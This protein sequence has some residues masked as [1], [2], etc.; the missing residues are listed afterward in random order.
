MERIGHRGAP[1]EFPEN[2]LPAFERALALGADAIE[3][4][5]HLSAD[6]VVV[7]HH[8]PDLHVEGSGTRGKRAI[9]ALPWS[10]LS[11]IELAPGVSIPSLEQVL[12]LVGSRAR[13]YVELKGEGVEARAIEVIG[14]SGARCAVHS[15]DHAVVARAAR[16]APTLRRGILFDEYPRDVVASMRAT[17]ALDVWPQWKLID[18]PL[19]E[20]VHEAGGRVIAWTVNTTTAARELA[21]LGSDGLCGDDVRLLTT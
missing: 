12:D 1:R 4:D 5:V 10:S 15:F 3:L 18:A 16:L 2:S 21:R 6:D 19:V 7:V 17:S 11:R 14:A 8:D 13:I 9:R 20:H